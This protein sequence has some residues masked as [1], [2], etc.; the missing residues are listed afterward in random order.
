MRNNGLPRGV[1]HLGI[2][3]PD[4]E[5]ASAFLVQ[6]FGAVPL[7]DNMTR[8]K[9]PFGGIEAQR[10]L[11]VVRGAEVVAMRMLK[12]G[13]G[14]GIELFEMRAPEQAKAAR[15]SD[16]GLQHFALYV[17]DIHAAASR[18]IEAGGVL[19]TEPGEQLGIEEGQGNFFC[20]GRTP[21]GT[22][23]ELLCTPD[24]SGFEDIEP[25]PRYVPPA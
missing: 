19:L 4:L 21:W 12:L 3:V 16:I 1:D 13:N 14:P 2:T 7:Y 24:R 6:A 8:D 15:T 10:V 25:V 17:D 11:G 22:T 5:A 20:Y 18:F 9:P 23:I